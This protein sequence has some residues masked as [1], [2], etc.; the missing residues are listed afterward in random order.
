MFCVVGLCALVANLGVLVWDLF[1][2]GTWSDAIEELLDQYYDSSVSESEPLLN[3]NGNGDGDVN[4]RGAAKKSSRP[5]SRSGSRP[6]SRPGTARNLT[7]AGYYT[8]GSHVSSATSA[9]AGAAA[10][11]NSKPAITATAGELP[12]DRSTNN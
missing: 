2:A 4:G 6:G 11:V 12:L 8:Y 5:N 7:K 9:S 1:F 10:S 3:A